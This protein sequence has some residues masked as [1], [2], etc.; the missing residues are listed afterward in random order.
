MTVRR[1]LNSVCDPPPNIVYQQHR[2]LSVATADKIAQQQLVTSFDCRPCPSVSS[3]R[4]GRTAPLCVVFRLDCDEA[5][6]LIA[7]DTLRFDVPH[8]LIV[9]DGTG[10]A[11]VD[12]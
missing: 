8:M 2:K 5:P 4:V 12:Q 9:V 6:N 7:L 11:S 3:G 1:K 10:Y